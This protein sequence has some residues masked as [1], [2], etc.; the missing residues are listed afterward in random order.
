MG[1]VVGNILTP[2]V[3]SAPPV[4]TANDG[5]VWQSQAEA[6]A[7][8]TEVQ[9]AQAQAEARQRGYTGEFGGG[10]YQRFLQEY[11][12]DPNNP[13]GRYVAANSSNTGRAG[14]DVSAERQAARDA[15]FTG[16]FGTG[17]YGRWQAEQRAA[18]ERADAASQHES[19]L[20]DIQ[21]QREEDNSYFSQR[22]KEIQDDRTS[23]E[24]KLP[25]QTN[26]AKAKSARGEIY[27]RLFGR[28]SL[29]SSTSTGFTR[30]TAL[31]G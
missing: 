4:F 25:K 19:R 14:Q 8:N 17:E 23:I 28:R 3:P 31:G 12:P 1:D 27:R 20:A 7:R 10:G 15:G 21:R 29:L 9:R 5:T 16:N 13:G 24:A 30:A 18:Q 11:A 2:S 22:L 6:D 26:E